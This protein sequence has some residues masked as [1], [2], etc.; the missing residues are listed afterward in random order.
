MKQVLL[1]RGSIFVEDVPAPCLEDGRVLLEVAYSFISP[2]TEIS[3]LKNSGMSLLERSWRQPENVIK[4]L[5][6]IRADGFSK[7]FSKIK[8]R[9]DDFRQTGY[10]CSGVVV[11]VSNNISDLRRGDKVACAGFT[12][13]SHA[14]VVS[15]PRNLVVKIPDG[16]RPAA[17]SSVALGA[18]A[19]QGVRRADNRFGETVV[20]LGLGLWA[21]RCSATH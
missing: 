13:A 14:E 9:L 16:C 6:E 2:G 7:T 21:D 12:M 15:V 20:V 11:N 1:R 5:N 10:S 17:A 3:D 4:A 19:V 8:A 18:I